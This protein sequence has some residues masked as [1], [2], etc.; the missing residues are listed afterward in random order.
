MFKYQ[1]CNILILFQ[2]KNFHILLYIIYYTRIKIC[3]TFSFSVSNSFS[4][5]I[6]N[7]W[8]AWHAKLTSVSHNAKT[9]YP[10]SF[11]KK[12]LKFS[13][14]YSTISFFYI[15]IEIYFHIQY[16]SNKH[17]K[18]PWLHRRLKSWLRKQTATWK[19]LISLITAN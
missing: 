3:N 15:S 17:V 7:H 8:H 19:N 18:A 5:R 9:I 4:F 13:H 12:F 1:I 14:N 6:V 16:L 11:E 10:W 2:K